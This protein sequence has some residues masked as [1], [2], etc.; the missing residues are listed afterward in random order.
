MT[1]TS[2]CVYCGAAPGIDPDYAAG[3][4]RLGQLMADSGIRLIYGGGEVGLMGIVARSVLRHGGT[5][6]GII[7]RFLKDREIMLREATDLIVTADMHER[8][9]LMFDRSDAFLALPGGIGTLEETVEM[10]T[11]AQLGQHAKPIV[12]ANLKGFWDPLV[13]LLKH[14]E[15]GGFLHAPRDGRS[16]YTSVDR[17]DEVLPTINGLVAAM[18]ANPPEARTYLM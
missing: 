9:R 2:L 14:M 8:K 13:A 12:L 11:W 18:P 5:V 3:A 16:L 4:E 1:F 6:T 10:M 15:G 17:I 7:P